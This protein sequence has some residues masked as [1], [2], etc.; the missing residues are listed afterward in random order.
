MPVEIQLLSMIKVKATHYLKYA[1][2]D[3]VHTSC[4]I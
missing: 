4:I 3:N 2:Y 1:N